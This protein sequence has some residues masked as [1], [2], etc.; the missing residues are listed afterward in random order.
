MDTITVL[1]FSSLE[2]SIGLSS[3]TTRSKYT[4]G[5]AKDAFHMLRLT[6][7]VAIWSLN[8][9]DGVNPEILDTQFPCCDYRVPEIPSKICNID[10][11]LMLVDV[12]TECAKKGLLVSPWVG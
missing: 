10:T 2:E 7:E 6:L 11:V 5:G 3:R 8:D 4:I 12:I 9:T 1:S